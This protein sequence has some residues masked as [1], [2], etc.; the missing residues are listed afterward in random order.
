MA[1]KSKPITIEIFVG[2][3]RVDKLTQEQKERM[4]QR[5]SEHMSL[6]YT[7]HPLEYQ[8]LKCEVIKNG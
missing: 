1:R 3:Q 5:L 2:D 4:A 7:Q 6:Y 8:R